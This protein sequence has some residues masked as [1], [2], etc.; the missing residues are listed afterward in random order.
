M[1]LPVI[2]ELATSGMAMGSLPR[3]YKSKTLLVIP[4]TSALLLENKD[5]HFIRIFAETTAAAIMMEKYL[6]SIKKIPAGPQ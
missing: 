1:E 2:I 6:R 3:G 4:T 5:D